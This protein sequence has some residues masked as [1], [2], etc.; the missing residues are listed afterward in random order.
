MD[1]RRSATS[2]DLPTVGTHR[3][4]F[5][6]FGD[7]EAFR[8]LRTAG[9]FDA[10]LGGSAVTIG[11]RDPSL[12]IP[13][14]TT[15]HETDEG[16]CVVWGEAFAPDGSD[17]A[18]W[19]LSRFATEKRAAFDGLDGSYVAVVDHDG[20]AIVA[21]DQIRSWECFYADVGETRAFSTDCAQV[22]QLLSDCPVSRRSLLE[23]LHLSIVLGDRTLFE[24]VRRVPFDGYLTADGVGPFS[25]FTYDPGS[26]DYATELASRLQAALERRAD[27]PGRTGLL[28]SAGQDS[29]S[30]LAGA[31]EIDH[32][33]TIG[34]PD[35]REGRVARRLADQYGVSHTLVAP[36][37]RYLT[38]HRPKIRYTGSLRESLHAHH[39]G[40]VDEF[41]VDTVYHGLLFDTLFKG[42]F[43]ARARSG[44]FG[45][46]LR[47]KRLSAD[48]DPVGVLLETLAYSPEE[49]R[50]LEACAGDL[51]PGVR[52]DLDDPRSFL[53][54]RIEAELATYGDRA[55]SPFN[56]I[57]LFVLHTQPAGA[58]R[59]HLADTFLESYVA[60]DAD[61]L[62]WHRRTPPRYRHPDT[63]HD[64]LAML[65]DEIFANP[66][67]G[68]PTGYELLNQIDR[69]A[70]RTLPW[71][72]AP[73]PV[74]PDRERLWAENDLDE[75]FFPDCSGL[76]Q[77]SARWKLRA[78]DARW[79]RERVEGPSAT[80]VG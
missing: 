54:D 22:G 42:Y 69:A 60:V 53:R 48:A 55:D 52:L 13:G 2:L 35:S 58:F 5:G 80:T 39:A 33:Y 1:G 3:E 29:R 26:F 16:L 50:R 73:E 30:F 15:F 37:V 44:L 68:R 66:P 14:R 72:D 47:R 51:F 57:D 76:G 23:F 25:R 65:D 20:S 21:T 64:A 12:G 78:N 77:L 9:E 67:P 56:R 70:R 46:D 10:V 41:D 75:Y 71:L 63:M 7:R 59:T 49:S 74:W 38:T 36:D 62:E 17:P 45:T 19:L 61:L 24:P 11:V 4:L 43:L 40:Y 28:L 8:T 32:C 18:R 31:P 34:S 79:W 27:Y 6:V